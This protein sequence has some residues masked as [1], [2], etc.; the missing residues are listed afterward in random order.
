MGAAPSPWI[1]HCISSS[2]SGG[3]GGGAGQSGLVSPVGDIAIRTIV[4]SRRRRR[5]IESTTTSAS[6]PSSGDTQ[7]LISS[8]TVAAAAAS[9]VVVA[10]IGDVWIVDIEQ[11]SLMPWFHVQLE[12]RNYCSTLHAKIACNK[13][14]IKPRH[15]APANAQTPLVRFVT[16]PLY[17]L[18]ISCRTRSI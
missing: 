5:E 12:A 3:G 14:H 4:T 8:P 13:L 6:A 16:D 10:T 18:S 17:R 11:R 1:R 2:S 9:V 15:S 7:R